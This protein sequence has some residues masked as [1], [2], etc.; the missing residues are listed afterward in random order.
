M[1]RK[2][3]LACALL[4]AGL[5]ALQFVKPARNESADRSP[6]D[7]TVKQ[8]VPA[9][10][11]ALLQRACYDC[12]SNNTHYPWYAA[13][14][15]VGWWLTWHVNDGKRHLDF[16]AFGTYPAKRVRSKLGEIADEVSTR[17][18]PL[19]SYTWMHPE[20][21]LTPAEIKLISDWAE[22]RQDELAPP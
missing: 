19:K 16:S 18:M 22:N 3:Q 1:K 6:N 21:R 13:V 15:P 4:L 17:G 11:A 5:I 10:V 7:I 12:H 8:P 20:A 9:D 14:Q 2:L